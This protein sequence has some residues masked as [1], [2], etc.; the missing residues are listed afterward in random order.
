MYIADLS[1]LMQRTIR[2]GITFMI[3][4]SG[5]TGYYNLYFAKHPKICRMTFDEVN[6]VIYHSADETHAMWES[7]DI[8]EVLR[9]VVEELKE[10]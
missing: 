2:L 3:S 5:I 4:Q 8:N 9:Y 10:E 7:D 6:K 1:P